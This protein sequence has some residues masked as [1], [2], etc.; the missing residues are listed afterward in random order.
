MNRR[1]IAAAALLLLS[2]QFC[3]SQTVAPISPTQIYERAHSSIVVILTVDKDDNL[4]SQGSGFIVAKDKIVTN[5]HV[6][7]GASRAVVVFADGLSSK[8]DGVVADSSPRDLTIL[9]AKT[10][11]RLSL[12]IGNEGAVHQGD[13]VYA[14][15]AP[16]GLELSITNG[17][18]S[19][20]RKLDEQFLIQT[21]AS[22]APGSSGG[23]LFDGQGNVVGVTTLY[24]SDSPGI[25]FSIG[26]EDIT[27]LIRTPGLSVMSFSDKFENK[28]DVTVPETSDNSPS[29]LAGSDKIRHPGISGTYSG[30]VHNTSAN[31]TSKFSIVIR[32][33]GE[34]VR[35]CMI[36]QRPLYGSGP[37]QGSVD[38]GELRFNVMSPLFHIV[39]DGTAEGGNISGTYVVTWPVRQD[40][41][42][43]LERRN[44][45]VSAAASDPNK[46]F[47][48]QPPS[49]P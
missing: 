23:P 46:C 26:A 40:G 41:R 32:N 13:A 30:S 15:G 5:H 4:L 33:E 29:S 34:I 22:I 1:G 3:I 21:T 37:I 25:Y 38:R 49:S 14:I 19:G 43:E 11:D 2:P 42:F 7:A 17:I 39:F 27:R 12:P 20:F 28:G 24:L 36:V 9:L 8:V 44:S 35:G 31:L 6:L 48:D 16:R 45:A 47:V 10:G 18:V